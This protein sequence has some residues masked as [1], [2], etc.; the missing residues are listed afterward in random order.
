MLQTD[1]DPQKTIRLRQRIYWLIGLLLT[2]FYIVFRGTQWRSGAEFH[3]LIEA[4]STVLAFIVGC[5]ALVRFYSKK[6]NTF[7]LIGTAFLGTAFLDGYHAIVTSTYFKAM[8]PSDLDSLIPWSWVAS[9]LYLALA[10]YLSWWAWRREQILGSE[11][12]RISAPMVYVIASILT[13]ISFFFFAFVPL[14]RAY[15]PELHFHRPE[16]FIASLFFLL[17][18][19]GYLRKG[20]WKTNKFEHWLVMSLVVNFIGQTVFMSYSGSLFDFEF[21]AAH[22]LKKVSYI[23]VLVG[24]LYAVY[25]AFR[26][27][28]TSRI[29]LEQTIERLAKEVEGRKQAQERL[30]AR[31]AELERSNEELQNFAYISSHDLQEPLRKVQ[32]FGDRLKSK[33]SDVLDDRGKDYLSR[34]QNASSRMASLINSLLDFSRVSSKGGELVSTNLNQ[35]LN[36]V[37]LDLEIAIKEREA[38]VEVAELPVIDA[39]PLQMRQLF[40]NL[41]SNALKYQDEGNKPHINVNGEIF[42][43]ELD[44]HGVCTSICCIEVK[45]NGIGFDQ[46]YSEQ[47]FEVFQRLH[48]REEHSG[49]GIGLSICRKIAERHGGSLTAVSKPGEGATFT[50]KMRTHHVKLED[51][52]EG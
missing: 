8:L 34:M 16:E 9:R 42:E 2:L 40:Q 13:L 39:D 7:L 11:R 45:D 21:D 41:I 46:K 12:G 24:L 33:Y 30:T 23:C 31:E 15:Y 14:P 47:I 49:T 18:L 4:L 28:E 19:I 48:G 52:Y 51:K 6:D 5:I 29:K 50:A 1:T 27:S 35:V 32:A 10:L 20:G 25:S 3:T 37:L 17:A 43:D 26:D 38:L 44:T 22:L 36:E